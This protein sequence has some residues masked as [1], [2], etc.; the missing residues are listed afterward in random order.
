MLEIPIL[1][2]IREYEAKQVGPFSTREVVCLII[3]GAFAYGS[4]FFQKSILGMDVVNSSLCMVLAFPALAFGWAKPY[5]MK[6]ERFLK[7]ALISNF[8]A[9]KTRLLRTNKDFLRKEIEGMYVLEDVVDDNDT[10]K[11]RKKKKEPVKKV[12]K[13]K[14]IKLYK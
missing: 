8:V 4:Y 3:G 5:G 10:S 9:P 6:L 14:N 11:K 13:S 12:K 1:K 7:S 2:D